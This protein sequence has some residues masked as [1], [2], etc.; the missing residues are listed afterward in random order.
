MKEVREAIILAGGKGT[1]LRSVTMNEFPKGLAEIQ[2]T[3]ILEWEIR[4]LMR[5]GIDRVIIATGHLGNM[6]EDYFGREYNNNG[7]SCEIMYSREKEKL[8]SGGAVKLASTK[9]VTDRCIVLNGDV[10]CNGNLTEFKRIHSEMGTPASMLLVQMRSPY[11]VVKFKDNLI[12]EFV[13]KPLLPVYIHSGI[14][15]FEKNILEQFPD[16]GQMEETIFVELA[17]S[18]QFSSY[19]LDTNYFWASIDTQ[20]DYTRVNENWN[21]I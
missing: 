19:V 4:W 9:M 13:E 15:L 18:N 12:E 2:D 20:K 5:E 7:N 8:G 10:L 11:G 17:N 1:R 6:I 16:K 14:D 3:P 21:G